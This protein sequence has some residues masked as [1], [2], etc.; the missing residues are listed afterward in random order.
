M[1]LN[2]NHHPHLL[3]HFHRIKFKKK[4]H[5]MSKNYKNNDLFKK[6]SK[7]VEYFFKLFEDS[8]LLIKLIN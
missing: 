3:K 1:L 6:L 2:K 5:P 4:H 8:S 7:K